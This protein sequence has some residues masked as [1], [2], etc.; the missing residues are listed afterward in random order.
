[1]A[2]LLNKKE[3]VVKIELTS[4]GR[5]VLGLGLFKPEY[6]SF[7]DDT[8]LYDQK[9]GGISTENQNEIKDRILNESLSIS[10]LNLTKD[11][12]LEPLGN[13]QI[14]GNA[15]AYAPSWELQILNGNITVDSVS[16][17]YYKKYFEINKME[18]AIGIQKNTTNI[19]NQ[20]LSQYNIDSERTLTVEEDYFLI[21]ISELNTD[22]FNENY[23]VEVFTY[24]DFSGGYSGSAPRQLNFFEKQTN[25]ID[26]ILYDE[27]ELPTRYRL[28]DLT[29]K[30]VEYYLDV[31]VDDE[32]D[33]N[34]IKPFAKPTL[35]LVEGT[36]TSNKAGKVFEDDC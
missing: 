13:S 31:L 3:D 30:D 23:I 11:I 22:N 33:S 26:G 34:F 9:Y 8:V 5:R 12:K 1:M 27:E 19:V 35:Q 29:T 28:N 36:Y 10:A 15:Y 24:D 7:F 4:Y 21:D 25:I 18:Y 14:I 20:N 32:I 2:D 17:S 16:S 6:F